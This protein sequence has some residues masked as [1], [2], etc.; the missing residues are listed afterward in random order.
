VEVFDPTTDT[1]TTIP[2]P[3][4]DVNWKGMFPARLYVSGLCDMPVASGYTFIAGFGPCEV[5]DNAN[6]TFTQVPA[7]PD[8]GTLFPN[9]WD[10][11][12]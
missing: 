5:Y 3:M 6:Q 1:F 4:I 9:Q 10:D 7:P 8:N 11:L 12:C 2:D